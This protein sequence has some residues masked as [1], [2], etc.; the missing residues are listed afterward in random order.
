ML[1][2]IAALCLLSACTASDDAKVE[3]SPST[4]PEGVSIPSYDFDRDEHGLAV[5][6]DQAL[7]RYRSCV[8]DNERFVEGTPLIELLEIKCH[9]AAG[10]AWSPGSTAEEIDALNKQAMDTTNCLREAGWDVPDPPLEKFGR[11]LQVNTRF[12]NDFAPENDSERQRYFNDVTA[13]VNAHSVDWH[14]WVH[15]RYSS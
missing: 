13:C 7:E 8:A 6:G 15:D 9:N 14:D 2:A 1:S 10:S 12:V 5:D 3:T 11:F 4:F